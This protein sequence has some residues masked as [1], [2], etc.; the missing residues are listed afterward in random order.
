MA[1]WMD[2][3]WFEII[4]ITC[5]DWYEFFLLFCYFACGQ[6]HATVDATIIQVERVTIVKVS[7]SEML[8]AEL[9]LFW[10]SILRLNWGMVLPQ[11]ICTNI[12]HN[13]TTRA[14]MQLIPTQHLKE[15]AHVPRRPYLILVA[16]AS[17]QVHVLVLEG[18]GRKTASDI[19]C[20]ASSAPRGVDAS[21]RWFT[22]QSNQ[23]SNLI[24]KK[25]SESANPRGPKGT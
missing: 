22:G 19:Y 5:Q 25:T 12:S 18:I 16:I 2:M 4:L 17:F 24:Q 13:H 11:M 10:G 21:W 9:S 20:S 3:D 6:F 23:S 8:A 1:I 15:R 7:H 14:S